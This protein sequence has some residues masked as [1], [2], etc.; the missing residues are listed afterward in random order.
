[1]Q[2]QY[3]YILKQ[4]LPLTLHNPEEES[5]I[6]LETGVKTG[7]G[8]NNIDILLTGKSKAGVSKIAIEMK[9]YRKIA[10]SGGTRGAHD[11]WSRHCAR[12]T[13]R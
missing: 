1:M 10:A 8:T 11:M 5:E 6:E 9:C 13:K 12:E 4:L 2:L 7:L 3:A